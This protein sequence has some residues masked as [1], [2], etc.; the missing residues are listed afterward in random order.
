MGQYITIL[1][2]L[3]GGV[4]G[5]TIG[6]I[7]GFALA[8]HRDVLA[9]L[10]HKPSNPFIAFVARRSSEFSSLE[11]LAYL[12]I[13]LI[14]CAVFFALCALPVLV[15]QWLVLPEGWWLPVA[16]LV[17]TVV[18]LLSYPIGKRLWL[19]YS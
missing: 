13:L 8:G 1:P 2:V 17:A 12:A 18:C 15:A 3:A 7:F 14:W 4:A 10:M 19:R 5:A 16:Y 6:T 11:S 9:G